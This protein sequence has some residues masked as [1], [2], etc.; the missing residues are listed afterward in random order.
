MIFFYHVYN[1]QS[2]ELKECGTYGK[3]LDFN[4][5]LIYEFK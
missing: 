1:L 2:F 5:T 4:L 3:D